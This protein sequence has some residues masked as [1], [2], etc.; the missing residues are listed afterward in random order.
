M[1]QGDLVEPSEV[2]AQKLSFAYT[3]LDPPK[4]VDQSCRERPEDLIA[5][6]E[7]EKHCFLQQRDSWPMA[8]KICSSLDRTTCQAKED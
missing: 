6:G 5:H 4:K 3:H 7:L 8:P 1:T 2:V